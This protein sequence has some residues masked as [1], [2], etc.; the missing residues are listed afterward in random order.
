[1][2]RL[3]IDIAIE[4][5]PGDN[6]TYRHVKFAGDAV[7]GISSSHFITFGLWF[8]AA[9][10]HG[11]AGLP[12]AAY[13]Y[14]HG[15]TGSD[16]IAVDMVNLSQQADLGIELSGNTNQAVA[17]LNAVVLPTDP[18]CLGQRCDAR[19]HLLRYIYRHK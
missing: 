10:N 5:I 19:R 9:G 7:Q 2:P 14:H 4:R 16:Q 17:L 11:K 18:V 13:G 1:M 12:G 3:Q 6:F 15:F 8:A